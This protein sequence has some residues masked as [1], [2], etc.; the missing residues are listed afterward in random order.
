MQ[1]FDWMFANH[2]ELI[3]YLENRLGISRKELT[4][5]TDVTHPVE[6]TWAFFSHTDSG[7]Y[8]EKSRPWV[9]FLDEDDNLHETVT[10]SYGRSTEPGLPPRCL[11]T[12]VHS[13]GRCF[14]NAPGSVQFHMPRLALLEET[15]S[16]SEIKSRSRRE[17]CT[18]EAPDF[19]LQLAIGLRAYQLKPNPGARSVLPYR[20]PN[21]GAS[22]G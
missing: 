12:P 2:E 20:I 13:H 18:R 15:H 10:T 7:T 19:A 16:L 21:L 1:N 17:L 6:V 22:F 4:E 11:N 9:L 8:R 3:S 5:F 14:I